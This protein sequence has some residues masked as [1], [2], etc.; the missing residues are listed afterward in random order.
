[1]LDQQF[2]EVFK[3]EAIKKNEKLIDHFFGMYQEQTKSKYLAFL[4]KLKK[5]AKDAEQLDEDTKYHFYELENLI[6]E[7]EKPSMII[8]TKL[9][10]NY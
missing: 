6:K 7:I 3:V 5:L 2:E 1:M 8:P 10:R 9:I 4:K